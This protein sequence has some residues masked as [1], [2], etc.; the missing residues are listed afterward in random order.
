VRTLLAVILLILSLSSQVWAQLVQTVEISSSPNPVGSGARALGMGGAFIGVADDATAASWNPAGLIQL[1]T[2][3]VSIVG[4]YNKRTENT[5]YKAFPEASG[6]QSTNTYEINY[7]S[8]A[9]PFTALNRN[10]IVSLNFQHLYDFNKKVNFGYTSSDTTG[11]P[12]SLKNNIH[13]NQE[14]AFKSLSPAFAFQI[15]PFLSLG[16]TLNLWDCGAY[17]NKW[18]STYQSFGNG[19]FVGFPFNVQSRIDD[20]Y[21]MKGLRM[22]LSD[23]FHWQN[24]NYNMGLLWHISP[25]W[26]LGAVFKA[27]FVANLQHDY[28][29]KSTTTFPTNPAANSNNEINRSETVKLDMPMSYG[30]GIALRLSDRLTFDLD[31]YR[32]EW[33]DYVLHDA[34][35]YELNPITGKLRKNSDVSA[36]T[37]VRIGGEYLIIGKSTVIP[38]RAGVFYDPEPADGSPDDFYGF[39]IGS[40]I[41]Y[42]NIV[43]DVAYQYRFGRDV[44][45]ATVG[46]ADSSQNVKQHMIYMSVIYHF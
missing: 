35:G 40:G 17:K 5:T 37:Q 6:P 29:F 26:T 33:G 12:L 3:E 28:H 7:L 25:T 44:R 43:Y 30:L 46:N 38:I 42:K 19:T 20:K 15:T 10:M 4:A 34:D 11:P 8:A 9:Y 41:A 31:V 24:V 23:P 2:S 39:S 22:D 21:E 32:T 14:G 27:P 18:E 36:T 1:E 13:F 16:V 45:T